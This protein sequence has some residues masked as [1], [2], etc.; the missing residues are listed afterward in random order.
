ML[1]RLAVACVAV[2][3]FAGFSASRAK[4]DGTNVVTT[5]TVDNFDFTISGNSYTW[6][7]TLPPVIQNI[8]PNESFELADT[9][10]AYNGT[11]TS[12][13]L[14]QFYTPGLGG[15]FLLEGGL[16]PTLDVTGPSLFG[17][18]STSAPVFNLGT[19]TDDFTDGL[20]GNVGSLMVT[21]SVTNTPEPGTLLLTGIGVLALFWIARKKNCFGL[22]A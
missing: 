4:A 10:Y 17:D 9:S 15:G 1:H 16:G 20:S 5:T 13:T 7:V 6:S 2:V 14:F 12:A 8:V 22:A 21:Q 3:M 11:G 19:F 18:T